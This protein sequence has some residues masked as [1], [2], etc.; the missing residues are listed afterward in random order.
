[1][2][3]DA[4]L[5]RLLGET[6][7]GLT[8]PDGGP[9]AV[10]DARDRAI[11][12][13]MAE[14]R[15]AS[16]GGRALKLSAALKRPPRRY[17]VAAA[18]VVVVGTVIGLTISSDSS[19]HQAPT[20]VSRSAAHPSTKAD[21]GTG[22]VAGTPVYGAGGA[23]T[24]SGAAIS[25]TA[26]SSGGTA[27][28]PAASPPT[29]PLVQTKVIKTASVGLQIKDGTLTAVME[30]LTNIAGGEGGYVQ[31]SGTNSPSGGQPA[32]GNT[33]LR[34][35]V[36]NFSPALGQVEAL[37]QPLSVTASGQ[38]VTSQYADLQAQLQALDDSRTQYEQIL[39][40]AQSITDILAVEQQISSVQS[41]IDQIQGQINVMNDQTSYSTITVNVSEA[42]AK[43]AVKPPP[44]PPSGLS[45]AWAHAR[46]SFTHGVEAVIGASGGFAVFVISVA[47]VV[48]IG[49][50]LWTR[51]RRRLL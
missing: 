47:I 7:D 42:P 32:T 35:P 24:G 20:A 5:E 10:L 37:G 48:L 39:T 15:S 51:T 21:S 27:I 3:D 22:A 23:A 34:I 45:K 46:H 43:S 19:H 6:A 13:T 17:L 36:A 9:A 50:V 2:I 41:Q 38:D 26:G 12:G 8:I 4:V 14:S 30:R 16:E 28:A 18:A 44:G 40:Q 25:A 33:T 31:T 1:M 11:V 49:R 29:V